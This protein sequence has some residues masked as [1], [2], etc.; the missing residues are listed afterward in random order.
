LEKRLSA[1]ERTPQ[2]PTS[3]V[4]TGSVTIKGGQ[5]RTIRDN[6]NEGSIGI[7]SNVTINGEQGMSISIQRSDNVKGA[8]FYTPNTG[9]TIDGNPLV[10]M[11]TV[12]GAGVNS[13]QPYHTFELYDKS[14]DVILADTY[15]GRRG[16]GAPEMHQTFTN[17]SYFSTTL[18]SF[19]FIM[20]SEWYMYHPQC[21]I[22]MLIQNDPAVSSE[23]RVTEN[24]GTFNSVVSFAAG[25]YDYYNFNV[26]RSKMAWGDTNGNTA[27][28]NVE[29]RLVAGAGNAKTQIISVMGCDQ[30]WFLPF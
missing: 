1:L 27:A 16:F 17:S 9:R 28:L 13:P 22:R 11:A 26:P 23:I 15:N 5:L 12:D 21:R 8:S 3:G 10:R 24:G 4:N 20:S 7:G 19:T 29:H 14:G 2:L 6:A 25:F 18:T 30:S